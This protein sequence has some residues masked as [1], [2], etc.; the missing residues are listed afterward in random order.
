MITVHHGV[1]NRDKGTPVLVNPVAIASIM[2]GRITDAKA[3]IDFIDGRSLHTFES[4]QQIKTLLDSSRK[5]GE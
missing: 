5:A 1:Y 4:V 3:T 2:D